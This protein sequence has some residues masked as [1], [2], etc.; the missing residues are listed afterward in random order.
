MVGILC[1]NMVNHNEWI[2]DCIARFVL[3][4]SWELSYR[5]YNTGFS[6]AF[7]TQFEGEHIQM[8]CLAIFLMVQYNTLLW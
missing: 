2:A 6:T 4:L 1:V 8:D 7:Y 5:L 3:I